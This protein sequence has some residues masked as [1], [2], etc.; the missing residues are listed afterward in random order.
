M[1]GRNGAGADSLFADQPL[2]SFSHTES[3]QE[4]TGPISCSAS[5]KLT[6]NHEWAV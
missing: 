2:S 5:E 6:I 1:A 3:V 4:W